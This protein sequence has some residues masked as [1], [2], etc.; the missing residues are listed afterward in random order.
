MKQDAKRSYTTRLMACLSDYQEQSSPFEPDTRRT[1]LLLYSDNDASVL[2]LDKYETLR[3]Q[4]LEKEGWGEK[5]TEEY[6]DKAL[7]QLFRRLKQEDN[8]RNALANFTELV[9][10]VENY[11]QEHIV[12][13]PVSGIEMQID[14]LPIG[15]I[16][17]I[18]MTDEFYESLAKKIEATLTKP[19]RTQ[20][21]IQ[22]FAQRWLKDFKEG[23]CAEYCCIAE[24]DRANERAEEEC[25]RIFDL[26]RYSI[27]MMGQDHYRVAV[28]RLGEVNRFVRSTPVISSDGQS[29]VISSRA[30]GPLAFFRIAPDTIE[31]MKQLGVFGVA[32]LLKQK[33]DERSFGEIL[34]R[35]I[36]W[37]SNAQI[38]GVKE[39]QYL[40]L[41]TCLETFLTPGDP[42]EKISNTIAEGVAFV[43]SNE[44]EKRK[45]L[46]KKVKDLYNK[47]SKVS[48]GG[49]SAVL[50]SDLKVL[51]TI[52]GD[53]L[54]QMIQRIDEFQTRND[55]EEWIEDQ[56]F[57]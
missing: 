55:L 14:R 42:N 39:N 7:K 48:H 21:Q 30:I 5:F 6:I 25:Q 11:A 13:L 12:Y 49:H 10:E 37:F 41:T 34:L 9:D 38:Q 54:S 27:H 50:D 26:F 45:Q 8:N 29:F 32:E 46:K 40:N 4:L 47:R 23:V 57:G 16:T 3:R 56:K 2:D 28:G 36:R 33:I 22:Q 19:E 24:P 52:T 1:D 53:F 31:S 43:L 15:N 20:E 18:Q 17:L 35:G 51:R 44:R